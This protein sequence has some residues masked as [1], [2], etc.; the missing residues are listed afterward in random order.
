MS[1]R[2]GPL[3]CI[4]GSGIGEMLDFGD[5]YTSGG[6]P[7]PAPAPI[8]PAPT[9][10]RPADIV[11]YSSTFQAMVRRQYP[12]LY[13]DPSLRPAIMRAAYLIQER[14]V[15]AAPTVSKV[16]GPVAQAAK[17]P[18]STP[19]ASS[20]F[21][22]SPAPPVVMLPPMVAPT[23]PETTTPGAS[24]ADE[25]KYIQEELARYGEKLKASLLNTQ[26]QP[27]DVLL[28]PTGSPKTVPIPPGNL[29]RY[30]LM[31]AA[32]ERKL[33]KER[34]DWRAWQK[35]GQEEWSALQ[36]RNEAARQEQT[37]AA[38]AR[39]DRED[40][41]RREEA[42]LEKAELAAK[43]A[44]E[45]ERR[46]AYDER[47][48]ARLR[49]EQAESEARQTEAAQAEEERLAMERNVAEHQA[50]VAETARREDEQRAAA[51]AAALRASA[52]RTRQVELARA[53]REGLPPSASKILGR[54]LKAEIA[55]AAAGGGES[56][57]QRWR[58]ATEGQGGKVW[59]AKL[60]EQL[61]TIIARQLPSNFVNGLSTDAR[62]ALESEI[63]D[64]VA[65]DMESGSGTAVK[66]YLA[67]VL[68]DA[69]LKTAGLTSADVN[70]AMQASQSFAGRQIALAKLAE[71]KAD[72]LRELFDM[73]PQRYDPK[74]FANPYAY[75]DKAAAAEKMAAIAAE[76]KVLLRPEIVSAGMQVTHRAERQ[77]LERIAEMANRALETG[78]TRSL[79]VQ[80]GQQDP[81]Q[82]ANVNIPVT[83]ER[84]AWLDK[85]N[86]AATTAARGTRAEGVVV[87]NGI[88][89]LAQMDVLARQQA[90][91]VERGQNVEMFGLVKNADNARDAAKAAVLR[92][93]ADHGAMI[94]QS[95]AASDPMVKQVLRYYGLKLP[96][97]PAQSMRGLDGFLD[98][99]RA[100]WSM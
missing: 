51:S 10:T 69:A 77:D 75:A 30:R 8:A 50:R 48:S 21:T 53:E 55:I 4:T 65:V 98:D 39:A 45:E 17:S 68:H 87:A 80:T 12:A 29:A 24:A 84:I 47:E 90:A 78:V 43:A 13:S 52:E 42:R 72:R 16:T 11:P 37:Q 28:R 93:V 100:G 85:F 97:A 63:A 64:R 15:A 73:P 41:R 95:G 91:Q 40:A 96:Q 49:V 34:A 76:T 92:Y 94:A 9:P 33:R 62:K 46:A 31:M 59:D 7:A 88:K 99:F 86:Y 22:I 6:T 67:N 58:A 5:S 60:N 27:L 14:T 35:Q 1:K 23:L 26:V 38:Q 70:Q 54:Q 61:T 36:Q 57:I 18:V 32:Y 82:G 81:W 83:K 89:G 56:D 44:L 3:G 20:E 66:T 79:S 25:E 2:R 19:T 71:A 74:D